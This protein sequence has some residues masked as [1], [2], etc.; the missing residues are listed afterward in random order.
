[1]NLLAGEGIDLPMVQRLRNDGHEVIYVAEMDP[2]ISDGQ[3]LAIA[4]DRNALLSKADNDFGELVLRLHPISAGVLLIR[5]AGL[6]P[7]KKATLLSSVVREHG[8][9]LIQTF[10]FV[11]P[12]MVR[13]R[14][15]VT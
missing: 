7:T 15:R 6:S 13:V 8:E 11:T 1:M 9:K 10:T 14:P 5:F 2:G 12:G 4:N 3:A